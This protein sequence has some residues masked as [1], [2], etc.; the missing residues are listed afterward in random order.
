MHLRLKLTSQK[1]SNNCVIK[2]S[3]KFLTKKLTDVCALT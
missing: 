3:G 2:P 1:P